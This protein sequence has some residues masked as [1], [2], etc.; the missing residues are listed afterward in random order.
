MHV[1]E[2]RNIPVVILAGGRGY[3]LRE[4][5]EFRPKPMVEI[6]GRPILW[7]IMK[8]YAHYGFTNFIICLG[9]KG[10]IIK[11]YFLNYEYM[12]RDF[13]IRLGQQ[14]S[15]ILHDHHPEEDWTVT[16]A[17]TGLETNTGGRVYR[18]RRYIPGDTFFMTYGDGVADIN[19]DELLSF[20][21]R[22]GRI[23]TVTGVR[24]LSRFGVVEMNDEGL[25]QRFREK[26]QLDGIVSGGFF[27]FN[28]RVFD[29]LDDNVVL[30][31]E[32]LRRLAEDGQLALYEHK[33]F[34]KS[35]DTY[36]D[37]LEFNRM[38]EEGNTPW[39][40]WED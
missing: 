24:P 4:E 14:N 11:E 30:E 31:Q 6:G 32:P 29:Y 33:G 40:V 20:H 1:E 10:Y 19:I 36:R 27:V 28:T 9:Y 37:W 38:W 34:W 26:P 2:K 8:I 5:T 7:H 18:I 15:V 25:V 16:L 22:M 39:K 23:A 13:T 35:M 17:D 21:R 12:H 3:R